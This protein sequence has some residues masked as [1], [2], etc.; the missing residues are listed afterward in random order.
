[1]SKPGYLV[2]TSAFVRF[3]REP[4]LRSAWRE[5]FGAGLIAVCPVTELEIF[6]GARSKANRDF[7]QVAEVTGQ[8]VRWV[9]EP[10]TI[11]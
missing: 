10:G 7:L 5:Q 4:E 11:V 3:A 9:A 1:M 8:P 6:Y 2:D